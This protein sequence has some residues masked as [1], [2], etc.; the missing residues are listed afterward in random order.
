VPL[1]ATVAQLLSHSPRARFIVCYQERAAATTEYLL[2]LASEHQFAHRVIDGAP[3][4][5]HC[6]IPTHRDIKFF[7][8]TRLS[9]Q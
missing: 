9:S 4:L 5:P 7:V 8:F 6:S 1:W 2:R 3:Y